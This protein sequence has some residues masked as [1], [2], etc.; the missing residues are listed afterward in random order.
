MNE[1]LELYPGLHAETWYEDE[2]RSVALVTLSG[3]NNRIVNHRSD[4]RYEVMA[5][6]GMFIIG[7]SNVQYVEKGAAICIP[8]GTQYQDEGNL[9]MLATATPPFNPTDIET[10]S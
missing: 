9:M 5:G 3:L 6:C 10:L 1:K 8:A 7:D 2:E 4:M